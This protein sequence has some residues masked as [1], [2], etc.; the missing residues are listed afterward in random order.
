MKK[1]AI[2]TS[3]LAL[4]FLISCLSNVATVQTE[5]AT[6]LST[7]TTMSTQTVTITAT[8]TL[9]YWRWSNAL[10][11]FND[12]EVLSDSEVWVVGQGV[13]VHDRPKVMH[14]TGSYEFSR[15]FDFGSQLLSAIDFI[16]PND[17]WLIVWGGGQISHWNGK[18]WTDI[19]PFDFK[20]PILLDIKFANKNMGWAVGCYHEESEIAVI[21]QWNGKSWENQPLSGEINDGYCLTGIDVVSETNAWAIGAKYEKGVLLH[22]NGSTWQEISL[23]LE[24]KSTIYN[25]SIS[26]TG[27]S[28]VWVS[29]FDT[30]SHWNGSIWHTTTLPFFSWYSENTSVS[31]GILALSDNDVWVGGRSLFH[32]NGNTWDNANYDTNNDYIVDIEADS[33]GNIWALTMLGRILQL[34]NETR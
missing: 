23:P 7:Q 4:L 27:A 21:M 20:N 16:T 13:I 31:P 17:G 1:I 9:K 5:A 6:A 14:L 3:L 32:W 12:M 29:G 8:P 18:E 25:N 34:Y 15:E 11:T 19:V 10:V 2:A 33:D 28:D 26:A 22:W 24:F 30:I